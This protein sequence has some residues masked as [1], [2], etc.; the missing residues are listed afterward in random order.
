MTSE[1]Q[2]LRLEQSMDGLTK[3]LTDSMGNTTSFVGV[4]SN[5]TL[6]TR[7]ESDSWKID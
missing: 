3:V 7:S 6:L 5:N 1:N 2:V 4:S